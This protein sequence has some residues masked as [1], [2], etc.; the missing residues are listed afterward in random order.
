MDGG[1]EGYPL[2]AGLLVSLLWLAAMPNSNCS[3]E[4][5]PAVGEIGVLPAESFPP[6]CTWKGLSHSVFLEVAVPGLVGVPGLLAAGLPIGAGMARLVEL[7]LKR[8]LMLRSDEWNRE[9]PRPGAR[10]AARSTME[11]AAPP[12]PMYGAR[13]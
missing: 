3:R 8:V 13:H 6:K 12:P 11:D 9:L 10:G 7:P 2:I 5:F 4:F 1:G